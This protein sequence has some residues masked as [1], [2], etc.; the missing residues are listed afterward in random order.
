M[1]LYPAQLG[2]TALIASTAFALWATGP[3]DA[4]HGDD[5]PIRHAVETCRADQGRLTVTGQGESR[6]APDM[7]Q[8]QVGVTV[9][10]DT[11]SEA[12]SQNSQQQAS[13]IE[14]LKNAGVEAKD[15][16]T[17]GLDLS[18][19]RNYGDNRSSE[20]TGYQARNMVSVRVNEIA[21]LGTV[22][23]ALV[24]AGANEIN[25]I[26]FG[27]EDSAQATDDARRSAVAD[28]RHK[29]ELLAEAAGL[30]LG[31][32]LRIDDSAQSGG[33]P[34]PM[35]MRAEAD[36][37]HSVPVEAGEVGFGAQ[38]QMVFQLVDE[39]A[40]PHMPHRKKGH[41]HDDHPAPDGDEAPE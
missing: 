1:N 4:G 3:A 34:R 11:A 21:S 6:M 37:S 16:Q 30:T 13:V 5:G 17:S 36:M 38:V 39:N 2:R 18:P 12:M 7:A 8:I 28:A 19:M 23:D 33:G 25:G 14:A 27:R 22:L 41:D 9:Q 20:V 10:A 24:D 29:A 15:I 40:C 26:S 31:S 32:V 35:M